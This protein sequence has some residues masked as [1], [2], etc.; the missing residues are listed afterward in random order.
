MKILWGLEVEDENRKKMDIE[1]LISELGDCV[2]YIAA[3]CHI[4]NLSFSDAIDEAAVRFT[5]REEAR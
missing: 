2:F 4:N 1:N 3:G 5:G